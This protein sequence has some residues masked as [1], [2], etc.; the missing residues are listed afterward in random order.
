MPDPV[1]IQRD[2]YRRTAAQYD[3]RHVHAD[4]EHNL[5]LWFMLSMIRYLECR[6]VLDIGSGTG[7]ALLVLKEE[8]PGVSLC[9]IEPSA[10]LRVA[11][12]AKGLAPDEIVDGDAQALKYK[13]G[14]FDMVCAFG[15]LHH[16]PKPSLAVG[17]M[18]RV[19][20]RAIFISDANNFGQGLAPVR[21]V[22]QIA[23]S[24]GLWPLLDFI[25][26]RGKGYIVSEGDGLSYSYSVFNNYAQVRRMCESAHLL[27]T[28]DARVN[29]YRT[30]ATVALLGIKP[31]T[32]T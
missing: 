19:A 9:G 23:N 21:A 30:A 31:R 17:E 8:V 15:A 12:Q 18:L 5:A 28:T 27:N 24:L 4:G 32:A 13:D 10:E 6:S 2:Y 22:K 26:S 1:T 16:I 25:K 3:A 20:K 7:R 14:E 11:A 29:P